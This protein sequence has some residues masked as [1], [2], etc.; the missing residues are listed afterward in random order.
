[1]LLNYLKVSKYLE[2]KKTFF[3][4]SKNVFFCLIYIFC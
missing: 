3:E 4:N 1:M 2:N